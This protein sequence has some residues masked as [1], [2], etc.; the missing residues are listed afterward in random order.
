MRKRYRRLCWNFL[1]EV[2][3]FLNMYELTDENY[4]IYTHSGE[5]GRF[6]LTL[7][8]VD[9]RK[10]LQE[11][12]SRGRGTVFFSGTFLPLLYYRSLFSMRDDDYAICASSPFPREHLKVLVAND[13]SSKYTRR[14]QSEYER[15]A[16][17]SAD[18]FCEERKLFDI[19][20][21]LP[22][23]GGHSCNL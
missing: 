1:F 17:Y 13:V 2:R 19:L 8:C 6:L 21:L 14:E 10:N 4:V 15:M 22:Y 16:A 5:E 23:A 20:S 12:M 9:P 11:C 3:H 7:F 18:G